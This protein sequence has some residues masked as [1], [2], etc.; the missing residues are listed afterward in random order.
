MRPVHGI[1][2]R[3]QDVVGPGELSLVVTAAVPGRRLEGLDGFLDVLEREHVAG[4]PH[5]EPFLQ[6]MGVPD[7]EEAV[8]PSAGRQ[9]Q[10]MGPS[11]QYGTHFPPERGRQECVIDARQQAGTG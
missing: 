7:Q 10:V 3:R 5:E 9:P 8:G 2:V 1:E 6:A 4:G 11:G